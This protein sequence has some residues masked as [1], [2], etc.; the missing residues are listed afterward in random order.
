[1]THTSIDL[2]VHSTAS[3]GTFTPTQLVHYAISRGLL[4]FCPDGSRQ[5]GRSERSNVCCRA[6]LWKS[7]V[8]LNF[9]PFI[10]EVMSIL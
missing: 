7:S 3:D 8:E 10:R 6:P 9:L 4:S 5:R 2:H 1:M